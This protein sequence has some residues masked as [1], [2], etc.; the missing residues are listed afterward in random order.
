MKK[1]LLSCVALTLVLSL[2]CGCSG[3]DLSWFTDKF[4]TEEQ[5]EEEKRAAEAGEDGSKGPQTT[6][7]VTE[8]YSEVESF[9]LAIQR[10]YG[11]DPYNCESLNNRV[12]LSF[13]Y[14]PLFAITKECRPVGILAAAWSVS[15]DGLTTTVSLRPNVRFHNGQAL[16]AQDV[17]D[18]LAAARG[19]FYYGNRF[20]NIKSVDIVGDYTVSFTTT[21]S[22]EL[23]PLLLDFP[24]IP[25][26]SDPGN[27]PPGTGPYAY[28]GNKL[29]RNAD[30]WQ[31]GPALVEYPEISIT[32]AE[33]TAD[34]RDNFEYQNVNLVLTDPNSAAFAGFHN[35][36]ELWNETTTIMQYVGY[37][38]ESKVFSNYGL[39][40]AITYAIDREKIV[41]H[42]MGGFA[43]A[44]VLPCSPQASFYDSHLASTYAYDLPSCLQQLENA[45]V[46]DMDHDGI[47]DLYVPSLGY[48]VPVSGTMIVCSSNYQRVQAATDI[49]ASLNLLGCNLELK[50]ME[51][52]EY[53]TALQL[54]NFDLYY[55]EVRLSNNYDLTPFF[56]YGNS[57]CVGGLSDSTMQSLCS[58]MLT[59]TGNSYNLYKRLCERGYITPVLFKSTAAYT[60]RGVVSEPTEFIDWFLPA[61]LAE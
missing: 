16:M 15:E 55:G 40:S 22:C 7:I 44:A 43:E 38:L 61:Y 26:G 3:I 54:G 56:T 60:T 1:K 11:L 35:D 19:S 58:M 42:R 32:D 24:I 9:G 18:S 14:E 23:L 37:N 31:S 28:R 57:L 49:V 2:L 12:F 36:Y 27:Y 50:T 41:Q 48:N 59:N 46:S 4:R 29:I 34:I 13:I 5:I 30:W 25:S 21:H 47:L 53:R 8:V 33:T 10:E 20:R 17:V 6:A 45:S 52:S 39:R 51:Y